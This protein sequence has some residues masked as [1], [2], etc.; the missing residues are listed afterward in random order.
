MQKSSGFTPNLQYSWDKTS[1]DYHAHV[2]RIERMPSVVPD[3]PRQPKYP[4]VHR[5]FK[6]NYTPREEE[7]PPKS[8]NSSQKKV[9]LSDHAEIV[10]SNISEEKAEVQEE[11]IDVKAD[12]FIQKK[13]RGFELCKWK[14]FK[15]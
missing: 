12:G 6:N 13:F 2:S 11:S 7:Q 8:N 9:Q 10:E 15:M 3:V 4:N 5:A 1:P 14:T